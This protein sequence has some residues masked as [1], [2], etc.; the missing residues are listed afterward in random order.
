MNAERIDLLV[1]SDIL[2]FILGCQAWG[3]K[4]KE[5]IL[6]LSHVMNRYISFVLFL[7][8]ASEQAETYSQYASKNLDLL[9]QGPHGIVG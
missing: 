8:Q 4:T 6:R 3:N 1:N 5:I 7:R 2:K 9:E